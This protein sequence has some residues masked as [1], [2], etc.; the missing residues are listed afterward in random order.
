MTLNNLELGNQLIEF[1]NVVKE[2][3]AKKNGIRI[4]FNAVDGVSLKLNSGES[5]AIVGAS[6]SGKSTL[7]KMDIPRT[8]I[9]D[10]A[11]FP[12]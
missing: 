3:K 9:K 8:Q 5:I 7:A 11:G 2:F 12:G 4:K 10:Q 6:G 1:D